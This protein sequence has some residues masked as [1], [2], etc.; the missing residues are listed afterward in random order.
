MLRYFEID[1]NL[2]Y[3]YNVFL[4]IALI[5]ASLIHEKQVENLPIGKYKIIFFRVLM[6]IGIII[7][8][9]GASLFEIISQNKSISLENF[10]NGLTFY[11]GLLI[12]LMTVFISGRI[13]KISILFLLNFYTKPLVLAHAI[14][15]IGCFFAGCCYGKPTNL[16][17]GVI[18][19]KGSLPYAHY[20]ELKIHPTQLYE[21]FFLF[22]LFFSM[23]KIKSNYHFVLYGISYG[24]FRFLI[25]LL[26]SDSRGIIFGLNFLSPSQIISIV[27][28]GFSAILLFKIKKVQIT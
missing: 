26:R 27:L 1:T 9:F 12:G 4:L 23:S 10:G 25:E 3:T 14:G 21:S 11:G 22:L 16:F 18:F 6:P 7:G 24:V 8:F 28:F 17:W 13:F 2:I 19:P 20:A 5:I 15:R